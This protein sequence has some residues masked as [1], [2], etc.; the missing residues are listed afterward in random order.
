MVDCV[1]MTRIQKERFQDPED[2]R[3]AAGK[4]IL[5]LERAT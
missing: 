1:Y 2:Y 5:T 3:T 4:Y